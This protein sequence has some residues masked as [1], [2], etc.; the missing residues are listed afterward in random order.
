M[1]PGSLK[2]IALIKPLTECRSPIQYAY[3]LLLTPSKLKIVDY[4]LHNQRLN[5]LD[6]DLV[7]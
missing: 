4:L 7:I 2:P 6:R 3:T 1:A 5:L